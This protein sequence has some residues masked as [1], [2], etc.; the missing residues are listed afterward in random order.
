M[1]LKQCAIIKR[2]RMLSPLRTRI[3]GPPLFFLE[4]NGHLTKESKLDIQ[5]LANLLI[6]FINA[7]TWA[8][9]K[10]IIETN[11]VLLTAEA[12]VVLELIGLKKIRFVQEGAK[13]PEVFL[14]FEFGV[15]TGTGAAIGVVKVKYDGSVE[16]FHQSV[17]S[18]LFQAIIEAIALSYYRDLVTPGKTYSYQPGN[19]PRRATQA[20]LP[21]SKKARKLPRRQ[22]IPTSK[23]RPSSLNVWY[24]AQ[25]RAKHDVVGHKR[26]IGKDFKADE[27]T[28]ELA[29][30]AG[31]E[32]P[33]GYTWVQGHQRGHSEK[34][35]LKLNGT[36]LTERILFSP[37]E[38]ASRELDNLLS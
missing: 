22:G 33:D 17:D 10:R 26:W 24:E 34:G 1:R 11:P 19:K 25:E 21:K 35:Q 20:R 29:R 18:A 4:Y 28:R 7:N 6:Q 9:S 5:Q 16:G 13:A 12:E 36:D 14:R 15:L 8:E 30:K 23:R 27:A 38:R 31:V 3:I 37:P 2:S 32:L